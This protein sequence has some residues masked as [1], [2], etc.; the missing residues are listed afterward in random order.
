MN[1][2][3]PIQEGILA[4]M[5]ITLLQ[6]LMAIT[7]SILASAYTTN[8]Q[9]LLERKV[10]INAKNENVKSILRSIEKQAGVSFSYRA[11]LVK[12]FTNITV[13]LNNL[14]ISDALDRLF[15]GSIEYEV[16]NNQIILRPTTKNDTT[17]NSSLP[18]FLRGISGKLTD[19]NNQPLPGVNVIVKGTTIG[20]TSDALGNY[21]IDVTKED[22]VLIFSFIGYKTQ[23]ISVNN[24][25]EI[26]IQMQ[27]DIQSLSEVVVTA[28][29]IEKE[30]K[31]IGFAVQE[32]GKNDLTDAREV[33]AAN[34]LTGKVAGVQ[35]S[36][37]A[38]GTGGSTKVI[39]RGN[40][41]LTGENQPLYVVDGIPLD[42]S[43]YGE[44]Q[45]FG[46]KDFGDGIGNINPQDIETMTV[47]KGPNA[48]ALYGSRGSNG[49]I[50][51]TT[52]SGKAGK[53]IGVE[54][55]S[56]TTFEKIN[57]IPKTQNKYAMGYEDINVYGN[58]IDING[59]F[60]ETIESWHNDSYGPPMDGRLFVNPFVLDANAPPTTFALLPQ[61]EGNV[62][63]FW[64]TGVVTNNTIAFSG[65]TEKS[66]ARLS[67]NNTSIKGITPMHSADQQ[68][69]N[70]RVA[71]KVT[72]K[73]SFDAKINYVR[74]D[75][76]NAPELGS[77]S[78]N[79]VYTLAILGRYVPLPFLKEYYEKTGERGSWP[80]VLQNP[81]YV[82]NELKNNSLKERTIG[83]GSVKYQ[84]NSWLSIAG[85]SGIDLSTER[86]NY[87]WPVGARGGDNADG[88]IVQETYTTKESN[89]DVI[90]TASKQNADNF[91]F[92]V[93][94]GG[95]LLNRE[96]SLQGWDARNFKAKG[97][98]DVSNTKDVRPTYS[99]VKR[100]LQ[101]I[102]FTGQVGYKNY[103]FLD[104]TGR[105]DWS[106]TLGEN[107]F[108]FFYPSVS[109]SFSF[110][111]AFTIERR[112]LSFGKIRA[113]YAEAGNDADP[114]LTQSS[115]TAYTTTF[116]GQNYASQSNIIPLFDLKNELKKSVE[117]G[118]DLRFFENRI[119]L[120]ATYYK[121][122]TE[123]QIVPISISNTSGYTTKIV[124]AGQIDNNG[125]EIALGLTP[126]RLSNTFQWDI[127]FN[128]AKNNSEVVT[129]A[130]GLETFLLFDSYPNDIEARPGEAY[131]N[132]VGYKYKRSPDGQRIV[133]SGGSYI[134]DDKISVL[135]NITP[136]W[137]GGLNNTFSF[138][139]FTLNA[140][141]DFVQ[142][143]EIT[144]ST[145]YQMVAKGIGAFTTEGREKSRP[146]DGVVELADGN[147]NV[148]GYAPNTTL[149]DG[150]TYWASRAWGDIGEEFV[151][152]GSYIMLREVILGYNFPPALISKTPFKNARI[153]LV[154]RNLWY[155]EEHMQDMGISPET[156]LNTAART[157][158]VEAMSMPTTRTYGVNINLTF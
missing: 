100:E 62:R 37:T 101:S 67:F 52:K 145:K 44:A 59:Q 146:L 60:Y 154:A 16:I 39:I 71:T 1:K 115:Y 6:L 143:N 65:G 87:R 4:F 74:K 45:L 58:L 9:Q 122:S 3:K 110:L 114:Y 156:V 137:T 68:S 64:E 92:S 136:D 112:I 158:G 120:D 14:K 21:S 133:N 18:E 81:Y 88:R 150:Q 151:L 123:N 149:V 43:R 131:G 46:G 79:Y 155:I 20:T 148:T 83:F 78:D 103:L 85:R 140:L 82:M 96:R 95:Y 49:V 63:D 139:G 73:L 33:S 61:P 98:Y 5:K 24:Q 15:D 94:L 118:I 130:P 102:F 135:G 124:N 25:T 105:N 142:G 134:A 29:G 10:S 12:T 89:S 11:E 7:F 86:R 32:L 113:S 17:S 99:L 72:D 152:D 23:E 34:Y 41:S 97:I 138:K 13:E 42:N 19:E 50:L 128:F 66:S 2:L 35:V 141:I 76:D 69:V 40:S 116:N 125:V 157:S 90:L 54:V 47:L 121:S 119:S 91:S 117:F 56:N 132:I 127:A 75:L 111:D 84:F 104:F 51:I 109:A 144:S 93:S 126:V 27:P 53:G 31:A 70:L 22:A 55:N 129:L 108:S 38:S 26:N 28:F 147:G 57:L 106:S 8:G 77:S 48:T 80:G 36:R 153:S 30:K 107:N